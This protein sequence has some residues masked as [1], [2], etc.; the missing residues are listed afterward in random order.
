MLPILFIVVGLLEMKLL[1]SMPQQLFVKV[2][3]VEDIADGKP[4]ICVMLMLCNKL[5]CLF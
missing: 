5:M 3:D 2:D 1:N 4:L